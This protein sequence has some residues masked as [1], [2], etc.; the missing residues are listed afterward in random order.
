[1]AVGA[2]GQLQDLAALVAQDRMEHVLKPELVRR[3]HPAMEGLNFKIAII[4]TQR[5]RKL[6]TCS[7]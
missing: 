1:M 6:A 2:I 5:A 3:H 7:M 4:Y